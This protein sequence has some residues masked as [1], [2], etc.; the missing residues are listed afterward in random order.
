M[1]RFRPLPLVSSVRLVGPVFNRVFLGIRGLEAGSSFRRYCSLSG[2]QRLPR[3]GPDR[4]EARAT[5]KWSAAPAVLSGRDCAR[6][7]AVARGKRRNGGSVSAASRGERP[8]ELETI[9]NRVCHLPEYV[10]GRVR[11]IPA[12]RAPKS[13]TAERLQQGR[14]TPR[15]GKPGAC[16]GQREQP[17]QVR[18][19]HGCLERRSILSNRRLRKR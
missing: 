12:H 5:W 16:E 2:A 15:T 3:F 13:R 11:L 17:Y 10:Y 6:R 14:R 18:Q 8:S 1:R 4:N 7:S 19:W 9:L